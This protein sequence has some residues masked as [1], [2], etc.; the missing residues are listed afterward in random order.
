MDGELIQRTGIAPDI[1]VEPTIQGIK[2]GRD[3]VLEAAI[4]YIKS[5]SEKEAMSK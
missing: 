1:P 3:E 5:N 2:E 4:E